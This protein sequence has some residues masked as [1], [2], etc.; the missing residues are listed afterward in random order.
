MRFTKNKPKVKMNENRAIKFTPS[1]PQ[2]LII[3]NN[4]I[5]ECKGTDVFMLDTSKFNHTRVPWVCNVVN[6]I[7]ADVPF[8]LV[9]D[10]EWNT[11]C[12]QCKKRNNH[13]VEFENGFPLSRMT[14][15]N[16]MLYPCSPKMSFGWL[17]IKGVRLATEH[18][19]K[20][21]DHSFIE[22]EHMKALF[23]TFNGYCMPLPLFSGVKI[24]HLSEAKT[25]A[26]ESDE[27]TVTC[28]SANTK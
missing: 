19:E 24:P 26:G 13:V 18:C 28:A 23:G 1:D 25:D 4:R 5:V 14:S 8:R 6:S 22:F 17:E 20:L 9:V 10:N 2:S 21:L 7:E 16:P 11:I 3:E 27:Q 15:F 12:S